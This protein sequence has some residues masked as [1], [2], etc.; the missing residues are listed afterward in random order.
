MGLMSKLKRFLHEC[1]L[2]QI[3]NGPYKF[4][5]QN[6]ERAPSI[7]V[8]SAIIQTGY[9]R[10]SLIPMPIELKNLKKII[11][12][13]PHQDDEVIGC[14]GL[15]A[16]LAELHYEIHVVFLTDG[17]DITPTLKNIRSQEAKIVAKN[18]NA[19]IYEVGISNLDLKITQSDLKY[20]TDVIDEVKPSA[21]FTTW[22]LDAPPKHRICSVLLNKAL[23]DSTCVT[24]AFPIY[25]YQVHTELIPNVYFDYTEFYDVKQRMIGQYESQMEY[26]NYMHLSSGLDAWNSRYLEWSSKKR[27]VE[28]YTLIPKE[29]YSELINMYKLNVEETFRHNDIFIQAYYSL[30]DLKRGENE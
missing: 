28:L 29:A 14:G 8:A 11:V 9:F 21:I 16:K 12:F 19:S 15:L 30:C 7:D 18:Y 23:D 27:Y 26:Q 10:K 1:K 4:L 22:V 17:G 3:K 20:I 24:E 13:A 2:Y 6:L 5:L 25:N